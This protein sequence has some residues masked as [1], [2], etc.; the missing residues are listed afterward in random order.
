MEDPWNKQLGDWSRNR[1]ELGHS[2]RDVQ[3]AVDEGIDL[4]LK[5]L[6]GRSVHLLDF[7]NWEARSAYFGWI[8]VANFRLS[9]QVL[10]QFGGG[11]G[12]FA[13]KH[14]REWT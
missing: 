2:R 3:A 14:L 9:C 8:E 7:L 10:S 12:G 5:V 1:R 13:R 11:C 4:V 6:I